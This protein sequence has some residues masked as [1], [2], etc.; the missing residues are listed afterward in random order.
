MNFE[1][2]EFQGVSVSS[3]GSMEDFLGQFEAPEDKYKVTPREIDTDNVVEVLNSG[4]NNVVEVVPEGGKAQEPVEEVPV[5]NKPNEGLNKE[6]KPGTNVEPSQ[7]VTETQE[8]TIYKS[9][10]K[11]LIKDG[12]WE[13][14]D[15]IEDE[16]GEITPLDKVNVDKELFYSII[17]Q[18]TEE[19]K[20]KA[21]EN[22]ISVDGV[23][24]FMKRM[25]ELD[26]KGG[27]VRSAIE[28]YN[29][30]K[31]PLE[32]LDLDK[33]EDQR[34]IIYLR[35]STE[36]K[37]DKQT[38]FDIIESR[39]KNGKLRETAEQAK[40]QMMKAV[41]MRLK[42]IEEQAA[43][44]LEQEKENIKRYRSQLSESLVN[45]FQL[46]DSSRNR[47]L[48]LATK[49]DKNGAYGID[50]MFDEAMS[51]PDK[52][53]KIIMLL[54]DEEEY[55]KQVSEKRVREDKINTMKSIR[56]VPKNKSSNMSISGKSDRVISDDKTFDPA[57]LFG[58]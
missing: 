15:G 1:T 46:K 40:E 23:S 32:K 24:D 44:R 10:I 39:E 50:L 20:N 18:K 57:A 30:F 47:L 14:F 37:L 22:K 33:V 55:N 21:T 56:L 5:S 27:D 29:E 11:D 48:D 58:G 28:T 13:D 38:I 52:A 2:N 17:A 35:Y 8:S 34:S 31:N 49:K 19:I 45:N 42:A 51:N 6:V 4:E 3:V 25:I 12:L 36:N 54:T 41:D 7:E 26:K 43:Q 53:A 9:V 16:N